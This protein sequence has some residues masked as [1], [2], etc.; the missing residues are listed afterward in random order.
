MRLGTGKGDG[1]RHPGPEQIALSHPLP[2]AANTRLTMVVAPPF[3]H[4]HYQPGRWQ[5]LFCATE[6]LVGKSVQIAKCR[7]I[8]ATVLKKASN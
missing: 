1:K 7:D 5:S 3:A 2:P 8:S 6:P 4:L